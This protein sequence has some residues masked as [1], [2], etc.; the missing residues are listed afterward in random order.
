MDEEDALVLQA[1]KDSSNKAKG[2]RARASRLSAEERSRIAREAAHARW[3]K[4]R[5]IEV[6]DGEEVYADDTQGV[7]D[8]EILAPG[9]GES[10]PTAQYKGV[11]RQM[12]DAD[13]PC[14]V[15]SDGRRV[16]GRTSATEMIT[17]IK[18]GGAFEKYIGV[19][20]LRPFIPLERV[21]DRMV[22]FRLPEV[23]GLE[24]HVRGL[25]ADELIEVCRGF[26]AALDASTR[27]DSGVR[28]TARQTEMALRAGM[29]L[30]SCAKVGPEALIDE[31]TGY[32]YE[33][34]QDALEV[35]LRAY[36]EVE[37]RQWEKTFPDE[38]W[39]EFG[40]L[41]G[42]SRSVTQRP[43]YWGKL[44][45]DLVYDYLDHDV[46]QW[47]KDNAPAP[48]HG[49]NYHQWLSSQ[50]GLRKLIEHIWKL[51]GIAKT[52]QSL[53]DLKDKMA[54]LHGRYPV[55]Y[56]FYLPPPDESK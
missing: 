21:V 46:A 32:Q 47:L 54:E 33:R 26:V 18:G 51:I 56:R 45:M 3:V 12:I 6:I 17:G 34:A 52:C 16:I 13:I 11:L 44:V 2:G 23:E 30:A 31:A 19:T 22:S 42:W 14:Y 35:K 36:L 37:M 49:K 40:R 8:G 43:K 7:L 27:P 15:L 1:P 10:L 24:R 25:P 38:L 53:S 39:V 4:R 28:L 29:F 5:G 55:Q 48:R 50:Y 9:E 20:A 41:T